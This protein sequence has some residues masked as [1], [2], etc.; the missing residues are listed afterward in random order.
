MRLVLTKNGF[1]RAKSCRLRSMVGRVSMTPDSTPAVVP[2]RDGEKSALASAVTSTVSVTVASCRVMGISVASPRE[3]TTPDN[4][5]VPK[6]L[7]AIS[8]S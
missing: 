4:D 2:D 8:R 1:T 3:T 6:P 7:R 5:C